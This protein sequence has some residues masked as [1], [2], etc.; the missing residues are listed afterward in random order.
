VILL[1]LDFDIPE[2]ACPVG[3]TLRIAADNGWEAWVNGGTSYYS[4]AV[5]SPGWET[6]LLQ[7]SDLQSNNW[8]RDLENPADGLITIP[9]SDLVNGTNTKNVL[10]ANEAYTLGDMG[11]NTLWPPLQI[12]P[13]Y[14]QRNPG[15]VIFQLDVEY[16]EPPTD[17]GID[18]PQTVCEGATDLVYISTSTTANSWTWSVTGDASIPGA[19]DQESVTVTAGTG[20]FDVE[21][22]VCINDCCA[23]Q[24]WIPVTVVEAPTDCGISGPQTACVGETGLVYTST[25]S[26]E[27]SRSWA[28]TGDAVITSAPPHTG[29]SITVTAGS[30]S[31]DVELTVCTDVDPAGAGEEDCCV[32]CSL[33]VTVESCEE[34]GGV[35]C[36]YT[37]GFYGNK[38]GKAC[39]GT[40]TPDLIMDLLDQA[41]KNAN[42]GYPVVVGDPPTNGITLY[43]AECIIALLPANSTPGPISPAGDYY[44]DKDLDNLAGLL[45][46]QGR[47]DNV[48]IGQVVALTLNL[49]LYDYG[50]TE[51][52]GDLAAW[53]LESEFC[54]TDGETCK[55]FTIPQA[56]LTYLGGGATVQDLLGL[57]NDALAGEDISPL[58]AS[59]VNDAV[60]AINEG[61]DKC[62]EQI[63]CPVEICNGIDDDCDGLIDEGCPN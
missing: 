49:R 23:E 26:E 51:D 13:S 40:K 4:D 14:Y 62:R 56:V 47:F 41:D 63:V 43:T 24:C 42:G 15:A 53:V 1:A 59:Q 61:F 27:D 9:A 38:G 8:E 50:C 46:K 11:T 54:T 36:A 60:S 44:C 22:I 39:D 2:S 30:A 52:V 19:T 33:P 21:L 34:P 18:G 58:T 17:C 25:G 31:F 28:V 45:T 3:A 37:Q 20:D 7:E 12:S 55:Q 10:A 16:D 6:T 32:T 48:L 29:T 35:L 5:S 57:A